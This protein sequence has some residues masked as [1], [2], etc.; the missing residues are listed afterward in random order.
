MYVSIPPHIVLLGLALP[1]AAIGQTAAE[2]TA[3]NLHL[4]ASTSGDNAPVVIALPG[5]SGVSLDPP[6]T[7]AGRPG[8]E[9]DV[10]FRR[11]YL[12]QVDRLNDEGF[13][14]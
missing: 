9:G 11:H 6:R 12:R 8:D 14:V 1:I 7:D 3:D 4:Y 13:D 2:R 10:L 5:C